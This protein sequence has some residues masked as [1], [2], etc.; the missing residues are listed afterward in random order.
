MVSNDLQVK[1]EADEKIGNDQG[2]NV[3]PTPGELLF[4]PNVIYAF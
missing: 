4:I 1:G 2:T 3:Y